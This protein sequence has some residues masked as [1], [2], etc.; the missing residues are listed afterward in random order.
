MST[1]R[2]RLGRARQIG[3]I[4]VEF[5]VRMWTSL[6][7]WILRRPVAEPGATPFGYSRRLMP[8]F[9][10]FIAVSAIEIPIIDLILPW[11]TVR[12]IVAALGV[13]GLVWMLGLLA[14]VRVTPHV[15]GES[16]LRVRGGSNG[17]DVTIPWDHITSIHAFTRTLQGKDMQVDHASGEA[18]LSLGV[19]KETNVDITF[20]DP[21]I[22]ELPR[23]DT[24]PLRALRIAV[25]D[26]DAMVS[27][28]REHLALSRA[29]ARRE[30]L[31]AA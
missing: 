24:E 21:T 19:L 25:D 28:A 2:Q 6:F 15:V 1:S 12:I 27:L 26:P 10:V 14:I 23:G 18:I 8:I 7:H 16:G 22:L 13:Y 30:R 29:A 17:L 31:A 4:A 11:K 5:E 3:R 9:A 20:G